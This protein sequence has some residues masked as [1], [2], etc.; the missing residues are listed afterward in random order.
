[1]PPP[2]TTSAV[3][4]GQVRVEK[5]VSHISPLPGLMS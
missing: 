1:L 4:F 3:R 2:E 5:S